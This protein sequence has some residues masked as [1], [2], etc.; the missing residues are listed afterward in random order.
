[1]KSNRSK[2]FTVIVM[3]CEDAPHARKLAAL[4]R[5]SFAHR[6]A[7]AANDD[8]SSEFSLMVTADSAASVRSAIFEAVGAARVVIGEMLWLCE[9]GQMTSEPPEFMQFSPPDQC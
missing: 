3:E 4:L 6:A 8:S 5:K 7:P 2:V 9:D 1:M